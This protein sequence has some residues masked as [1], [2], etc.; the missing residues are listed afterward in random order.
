MFSH[1]EISMKN[2]FSDD[3]YYTLDVGSP[4][5]AGTWTIQSASIS[6]LHGIQ[7]AIPQHIVRTQTFD[8]NFHGIPKVK[9]VTKCQ[10]FPYK[11]ITTIEHQSTNCVL[12]IRLQVV[13]AGEVLTGIDVSVSSTLPSDLQVHSPN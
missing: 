8:A 12:N 5:S 11:N 1:H 4:E 3:G 9:I 7:L 10:F 2:I 13:K 6:P